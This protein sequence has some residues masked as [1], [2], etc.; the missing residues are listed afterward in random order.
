MRGQRTTPRKPDTSPAEDTFQPRSAGHGLPRGGERRLDSLS[1]TRLPTRGEGLKLGDLFAQNAQNAE[2][3]ELKLVV[4]LRKGPACSL[5]SIKE[6]RRAGNQR[7]PTPSS[8]QGDAPGSCMPH[9]GSD[10]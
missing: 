9:R 1:V 6:A 10:K 5:Y 4:T 3:R 7:N 2:G 8:F